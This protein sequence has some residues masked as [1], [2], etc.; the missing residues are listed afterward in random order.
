MRERRFYVYEYRDP[1]GVPFYIGKGTGKRMWAHLK[2]CRDRRA[3][4]YHTSFY[5]ALRHVLDADILPAVQVVED[6][7]TWDEALALERAL[8]SEYGRLSHETGSLCNHTC[9]SP[10]R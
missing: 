8:I 1:R 2:A 7:L 6:R 9:G 10:P 3:R 5:R 4:G